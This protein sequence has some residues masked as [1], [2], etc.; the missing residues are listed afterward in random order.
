MAGPT[1][2]Q[3]FL[4]LCYQQGLLTPQQVQTRW[5]GLQALPEDA[6]E[7]GAMLRDIGLLTAYQ[8][9]RILAGQIYDLI[10]GPYRILRPLGEGGASQVYLAEQTTLKRLVALKMVRSD[11]EAALMDR[12]RLLREGQTGAALDHPNIVR[13]FDLCQIGTTTFLVLEYVEGV[14]LEQI[15]QRHG[16][17]ALPQ[18]VRLIVQVAAA[19]DHLH[20]RGLVHRDLKPSNLILMA[21]GTV[22]LL[23]MELAS[24]VQ[25]DAD[26]KQAVLVG[27]LGFMSPEQA[28]GKRLDAR[29]D[30]YSLGATLYCLL[31]GRALFQNPTEQRLAYLGLISVPPLQQTLEGVVPRGFLPIL[32][33]LMAYEP[34]QRFS[35][36]AELLDA[37][38]PWL[39]KPITVQMGDKAVLLGSQPKSRRWL[40]R[41][42][43]LLF[44]SAA[45][46]LAWLGGRRSEPPENFDQPVHLEP[47]PAT[48]AEVVFS[49][50]GQRLYGGDWSGK[51]HVWDL[52][53]KQRKLFFEES[54]HRAKILTLCTD[55][56]GK[57]LFTAGMFCPVRVLNLATGQQ[58]RELPAMGHRTWGLSV[59]PD[60]QYLALC[61]ETG[62]VLREW[63]TGRLVR[64]FPTM[65]S[66]H[67]TVAFSPDGRLLAVAGNNAPGKHRVIL[68]EVESGKQ[69]QAF[70]AK[71]Q[72]VRT[73]AF[74]PREPLL[75]AGDF[76]GFVCIWDYQTGRELA[77]FEALLQS[78][79]ERVQ[80]L[81][82]GRRLLIAGSQPEAANPDLPGLLL[83]DLDTQLEQYRWN[84]QE[85]LGLV[86][87]RVSPDGRWAVTGGKREGVRL[88]KIPPPPPQ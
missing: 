17:L 16:P 72:A 10:L 79:V 48:L 42:M 65:L 53:T 34:E 11:Q 61:G 24:P 59:S 25:S 37:L 26:Q 19:L 35:S 9:E 86:C 60:G 22:K 50:D 8:V 57:H 46:A 28:L 30:L 6:H 68:F 27:T 51:V 1:S 43:L 47:I 78:I 18:A 4:E 49:P 15:L 32:Q 36:A 21:D 5:P 85:L 20:R 87:M 2:A 3:A 66:Y 74:H 13:M 44:L 38:Q 82:Q 58:L 56:T 71:Q 54:D 14:D 80:F 77:Q 88:W 33:R 12:E 63:R 52:A 45:L 7:L 69:W 73:L 39:D 76:G 29:S 64:T 75:A 67:W 83:Y 70:A 40:G 84:L 23:D 81:P 31:S 41:S 55:P 62:L